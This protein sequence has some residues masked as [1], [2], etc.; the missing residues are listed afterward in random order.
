MGF[1][2]QFFTLSLNEST[3]RLAQGFKYISCFVDDHMDEPTL[4]ILNH[5]G[6]QIIALRSAGFNNVDLGAAKKLGIKIVR[7]PAYSPHGIAEHAV[8]LLLTLNR[9]THK[10]YARVREQNFSLEGLVG[11]NLFGKTVG[12]LGT[13]KIGRVFAQILLG[14]GCKILAYDTVANP[15]LVKLDSVNYVSLEEVLKGSDI[16]SLHLPLT[17]GTRHIIDANN[18]SL[19]KKGVV[20]INTGRGALVESA[21]LIS[22]LKSGHLGAAGLDVYEE[23]DGV[24]FNDLS[25]RVLQDD[26][27]A[28]LMTFPNVLITSHQAF[29]THE[30]LEN[31]A[32]V[33]L[34]NIRDFVDGKTLVN[35]VQVS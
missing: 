19:M 26:A 16:I 35:E 18:I 9:K 17:P 6:V 29:L 23:E 22:A 28:R 27:L 13:G 31:I 4:K 5:V 24:F 11:Y 20:L 32:A 10:A 30:A 21:A 8:A 14:F 15:D 25:S 12:V 34:R 3:A 7:V 2:I 33:T 1:Q